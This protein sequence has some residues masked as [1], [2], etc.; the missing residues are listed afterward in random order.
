MNTVFPVV[1]SV[2]HLASLW[3]APW[4]CQGV[5]GG[6]LLLSVRREEAGKGI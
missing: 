4:Q 6:I 1:V 2:F 3:V 5:K